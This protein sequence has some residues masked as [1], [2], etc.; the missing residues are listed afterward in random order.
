[1]GEITEM[2]NDVM[3]DQYCRLD[4]I[5]PKPKKN[6]I[7]MSEQNVVITG[8]IEKIFPIE[9]KSEKFK[10][11]D[12]VI[13]TG[14]DYPQE[15]KIQFVN[16]QCYLFE[17]INEGAEVDAHCNIRGRSWQPPTGELKYFNTIQG[18]RIDVVNDAGNKVL[19]AT[20]EQRTDPTVT[21]EQVIADLKDLQKPSDN[22][23]PF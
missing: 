18:W 14:G 10:K 13:N 23:L 12:I 20:T 4:P 3:L 7:N 22:D 1:M 19:D 2:M 6:K 17:E 9:Q 15:I 16:D 21:K 11:R 5:N 8:I